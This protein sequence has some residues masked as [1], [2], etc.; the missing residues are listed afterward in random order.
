MGIFLK[1]FGGAEH[2]SIVIY[3]IQDGRCDFYSKSVWAPFYWFSG[4]LKTN[5]VGERLLAHRP[6]K[7]NYIVS[8]REGNSEGSGG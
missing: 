7:N 3:E 4:V 2:E 1:V 6:I 8:I 5:L